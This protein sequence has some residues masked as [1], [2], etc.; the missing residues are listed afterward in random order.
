[1][2]RG[3][4]TPLVQALVV[5]KQIYEDTR[6]G[7]FLLIAPFNG[8]V[9]SAFP[10]TLHCSLYANVSG[11]HGHYEL[12]LQLRNSNDDIVWDWRLPRGL[13]HDDPLTPQKLVIY[14]LVMQLPSA[15]R[16]EFFMLANGAMMAQQ[17]LWFQLSKGGED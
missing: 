3:L 1:M 13:E 6:T 9:M 12:D 2:P 4:P 5:C 7:Q 17:S 16:Y 8:L 14:D 10:A 11:A 15:G